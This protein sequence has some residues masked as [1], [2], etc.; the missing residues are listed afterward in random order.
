MLLGGSKTDHIFLAD[1]LK[2]HLDEMHAIGANY[3]RCTMSQREGVDLKPHKRLPDGKFDLE[4]WNE[5]YWQRF[6]DCLQWCARAGHHY[7]D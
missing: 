1:E 4:Q 3:V 5:Q 6:A 7:A 2:P